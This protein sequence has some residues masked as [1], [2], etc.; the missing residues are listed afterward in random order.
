MIQIYK[1]R[2]RNEVPPHVFAV[3]DGAYCDMLTSKLYVK[4]SFSFYS[5]IV[6]EMVSH[7]AIS[8]G[9]DDEDM[10]YTCVSNI[11]SKRRKKLNSKVTKLLYNNFEVN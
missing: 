6:A 3:S 5:N 9:D 8:N 4:I 7:S 1:G 2:R 11:L 10:G